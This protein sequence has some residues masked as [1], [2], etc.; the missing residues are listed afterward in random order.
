[1][2]GLGGG[3]LPYN[4]RVV[5]VIVLVVTSVTAATVADFYAVEAHHVGTALLGSLEEVLVLAD[6]NELELSLVL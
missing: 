1:M 3:L 2:E 5:V 4:L 6:R